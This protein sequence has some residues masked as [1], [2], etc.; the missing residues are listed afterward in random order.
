MFFDLEALGGPITATHLQTATTAAAGATFN[1]EIYT[2]TGT[3]LGGPVAAGPGS[4]PAGWTSLGTV[5]GTQGAVGSG[6]SLDIDIPDIFIPA[7][8]VVGVAAIVTVAG[9]RYFGTG[10]PPYSV[11]EDSN[12]RLTTGDARSAPFTTTGSFFTSRA[13]AGS[14][15]YIPSPS[16]LALLGLGGLVALRRRR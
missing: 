9:P 4:S 8:S 1:I 3:A 13:L 2:R 10:T 12:L 7:G 11:F 14:V 5:V 16:S 15:T 6:V